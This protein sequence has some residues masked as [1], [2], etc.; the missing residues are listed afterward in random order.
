MY[1]VAQVADSMPGDQRRVLQYREA[2]SHLDEVHETPR[3]RVSRGLLVGE[4]GM[5]HLLCGSDIG[6]RRL[7]EHINED[8]LERRSQ[9]DERKPHM[10]VV[11]CRDPGRRR[12]LR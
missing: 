8:C 3:T 10:S 1:E 11:V 4:V 5:R 9:R 7:L 12:F 2:V 6:W